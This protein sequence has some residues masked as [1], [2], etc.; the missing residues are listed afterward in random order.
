MSRRL[1]M[2]MARELCDD[3]F[4][5]LDRKHRGYITPQQWVNHFYPPRNSTRS[6]ARRSGGRPPLDALRLHSFVWHV[7][8]CA[9]ARVRASRCILRSL[10]CPPC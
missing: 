10:T 8:A 2:N 6:A 1:G 5:L 7:R 9:H 3:M 4:A